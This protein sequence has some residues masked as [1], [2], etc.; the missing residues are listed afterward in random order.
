M[1]RWIGGLV[2]GLALGVG[3]VLLVTRFGVDDESL[4]ATPRS[5]DT[6]GSASQTTGAP[7]FGRRHSSLAEIQDIQSEFERT[8]ALYNLLESAD[9]DAIEA[10]LDEAGDLPTQA[11]VRAAKSVIYSRY[12]ELAPQ[13]TLRHIVA[14]TG[15]N[16]LALVPSM[17]AW[18]RND[19]DAAVAYIDTLDERLGTSVVLAILS[20]VEDL[21]DADQDRIAER[22][23]TQEYLWRIRASAEAKTNPLGAWQNALAMA[24]GKAGSQT[25]WSI[26]F[27]WFETDPAAALSALNDL[28]DPGNR[29]SW[30]RSLM[31]RWVATDHNAALHWALSLPNIPQRASLLVIA[32]KAAARESPSDV[33]GMARTLEGEEREQVVRAALNAWGQTDPVAALQALEGFNE[34]QM[35]AA[36]RGSL[37]AAWA[38]D[39]AEAA[40][41]WVLGQTA[42]DGRSALLSS[43]LGA[44]AVSDPRGALALASDLDG[45]ARPRAIEHV[46]RQWGRDD[47]RAAAAWLDSST[48]RSPSTVSAVVGAYTSLDPE[49]ALDWLLT[50]SVEAQRQSVSM[51]VRRVAEDSLQRAESLLDRIGDPMTRSAAGSTLLSNWVGID[52]RAAVRAITRMD[53]AS[54]PELYT[55][56]FNRWAGFDF[57]SATAYLNRVP[58][59]GRDGAIRGVMLQA[60]SRGET[61][62]AERMYERLDGEEARRRGAMTMFFWLSRNDNPRAAHY[63]ERAGIV[64]HSP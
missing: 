42:S 35:A 37:V 4:S 57:D 46:L 61:A 56:T 11:Q 50:Q 8:A 27:T 33:L 41:E 29:T 47:P 2:V 43:T 52:P 19:L 62:I 22:F 7:D 15:A 45:N 64:Q 25:L 6:A 24:E 12:V 20:T 32:A 48:D 58:S 23:S 17:V 28:P 31:N 14:Q 5:N 40:F 59:S 39:D 51:I 55:A 10:L 18:A 21:S 9:A 34:P 36:V 60:L 54:T 38:Q 44:L 30:Q 63:R 53:D 1:H 49:E 26:A 16:H 3:A 13:A